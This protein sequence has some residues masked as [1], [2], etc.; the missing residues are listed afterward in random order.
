MRTTL[1]LADDVIAAVEK[2][3]HERAI[4]V[5]EAVNELVRSGLANQNSPREPFRQQ[6]HDLG[7]GVD[8]NNIG[9]TMET[10]DGARAS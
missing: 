5:S 1:N 4:G 6:S 8:V 2:L 9:E 7:D 3:R 10:L